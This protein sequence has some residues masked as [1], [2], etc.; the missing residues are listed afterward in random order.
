[1]VFLD[2][3]NNVLIDRAVNQIMERHLDCIVC[4]DDLICSR[5]L[6]KL[7]EDNYSVPEDIKVA[8]FYN[9]AHL[10]SY[11]P[12][13]TSLSIN[14]KELGINGAKK[15]IDTISGLPEFRKPGLIMRLCLR[16]RPSKDLLICFY[17]G[18]LLTL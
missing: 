9:N 5:V 14:P 17:D 13:I 18:I 6:A 12:P 10:E 4:S 16:G 7:N 11:N 15:L 8:S 2:M 3:N 1:M